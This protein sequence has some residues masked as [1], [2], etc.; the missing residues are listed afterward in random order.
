MDKNLARN[1]KSIFE[2]RYVVPLYQRNF[3]WG[4]DE[5]E[6][7]FQ[8]IYDSF[9]TSRDSRYYIGTLVVIPRRNEHVFE[10]IDG[11]QRLTVLSLISKLLG[12]VDVPV[13]KYDSRPEV[14]DFLSDFYSIKKT[15]IDNLDKD[16]NVYFRDIPQTENLRT[17][18]SCIREV[19]VFKKEKDTSENSG[20]SEEKITLFESDE[21]EDFKKYFSEKVILIFEEMPDD[22]D[23]AAY[24]EIMNNR[25][26]QLQKHEILKAKFISQI[27]E[28]DSDKDRKREL[29][30]A[31]WDACSKMNVPVQRF[32]DSDSRKA[33]F[34]EG[35]DGFNCCWDGLLKENCNIKKDSGKNVDDDDD[36][37]EFGSIIDFPNFLMHVLKIYGIKSQNDNDI[38]IPLNEKNMPTDGKVGDPIKFA[39]A[40]LFFR[41]VFDRF[42]V[43]TSSKNNDD[44]QWVLYST[45]KQEYTKNDKVKASLRVDRATFGESYRKIFNDGKKTIEETEDLQDRII[46]ALSMLQVTFRQR[47]NKNWLQELLQWFWN[48]KCNWRKKEEKEEK[49]AFINLNLVS[50]TVYLNKIDSLMGDY[51]KNNIKE[52]TFVEDGDSWK[53]IIEKGEKT[54]HFLF[55]Y[56]D[57]LY[58]VYIVFKNR[59]RVI[60]PGIKI[61]ADSKF[62]S[63]IGSDENKGKQVIYSDF[64]FKYYNSVEHHYPQHPENENNN[65]KLKSLEN[66]GNLYLISKSINS[67]MSNQ[68]PVAKMEYKAENPNRRIMY[69]LTAQKGWNEDVIAEHY[70]DLVKLLQERDAILGIVNATTDSVK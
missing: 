4:K 15:D 10:V 65:M 16:L 5:I 17:A 25:G 28:T 20:K 51:F 33:L 58:W 42:I 34:G 56:I 57:Y 52:N 62:G 63:N 14:E 49:E 24:F 54:P 44:P 13:L 35:F 22:T 9:S 11:Q 2:E 30:A 38:Y 60:Y 23:V 55:N 68:L 19:E 21:L 67:K 29:F 7:L 64:S 31:V 26:E 46:K 66:L 18:L 1:I 37:S 41:V 40:L 32:F 12:I 61:I 59:E 48:N 6:Q 50:A 45:Y 70:K 36:D 27:D 47:I 8:D 43:K 69:Y 39:K 3:T 53:F